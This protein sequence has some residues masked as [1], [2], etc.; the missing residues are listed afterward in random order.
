MNKIALNQR[1]FA[2]TNQNPDKKY[3]ANVILIGRD[4]QP[5]KSVIIHCH[6]IEYDKSLIPGTYMNAEV[7]TKTETGNTVPDDASGN[8]GRQT[9]YFEEIQPK[10]IKCFL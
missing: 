8:L 1:V 9:I 5:D 6:F 2:Y 7:E 4:F 10:P 3:A